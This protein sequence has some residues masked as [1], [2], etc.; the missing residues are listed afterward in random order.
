MQRFQPAAGIC[1]LF[2]LCLL[3]LS[4]CSWTSRQLGMSDDSSQASGQ[5]PDGAT[6]SLPANANAADKRALLRLSFGI[7][8]P[9]HIDHKKQGPVQ[10][11]AS[12]TIP[13]KKSHPDSSRTA[14]NKM[15][16]KRTPLQKEDKPEQG[17]L[18]PVKEPEAEVKKSEPVPAAPQPVAKQESPAAPAPQIAEDQQDKGTV[19]DP[20][21]P[22]P[23][24]TLH[25]SVPMQ[26]AEQT[27]QEPAKPQ[28]PQ[29][30]ATPQQKERGD[31]VYGNTKALRQ[32][33]DKA[34]EQKSF[35]GYT[36]PFDAFPAIKGNDTMSAAFIP[37]DHPNHKV[38]Y[39]AFYTPDKPFNRR[40]YGYTVIDMITKKDYGHFDGNA[41]GKFEQNTLRPSV[42]FEDYARTSKAQYG[43]KMPEVKKEQEKKK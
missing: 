39:H 8:G 16:V 18:A 7:P 12:Y 26:H 13:P 20:N 6:N 34:V 5:D 4:G 27:P 40:V 43:E 31:I 2:T 24:K 38:F 36:D 10:T 32:A 23:P 41:D 3:L 14:K 19:I 21:G 29:N 30:A 35:L 1:L 25:T 37:V 17:S 9:I 33:V 42:I 22:Q 11:Q 15:V 28:P